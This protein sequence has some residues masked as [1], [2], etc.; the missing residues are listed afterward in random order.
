MTPAPASTAVP[1]Y[2]PP[3][4]PEGAAISPGKLVFPPSPVAVALGEEIAAHYGYGSTFLVD[5]CS[6]ALALVPLV[7][8]WGPGDEILVPA[9]AFPT[10]VSG[11]VWAGMRVRFVDVEPTTPTVSLARLQAARSPATRAVLVLQ[12]AG[13]H[14]ELPAIAAWCESEGL[15]L[16]EDAAQAIAAQQAGRYMGSFGRFAAISFGKTKNLSCGKGG[17]LVVNDPADLDRARA[18]LDHGTNRA[19][20][21]AGTVSEYVWTHLGTNAHLPDLQARVLAAFWPGLAAATRT[22]RRLWQ[23]YATQLGESLQLAGVGFAAPTVQ[24]VHNGHLFWLK[25]A[26]REQRDSL[27]SYLRAENIEAAF[28]YQNLAQAPFWGHDNSQTACP[29]AQAWADGLVRLPLYERLS[30][31]AQDR[32]IEAVRRWAH[33]QTGA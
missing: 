4:L 3:A 1:F 14:P 28:H 31:T 12:Y 29:N 18:V 6:L 24:E 7:A 26:T 10:T 2:Q 13:L 16:V 25:C 9:F 17:A 32:V 27:I 30:E 11:F 22:R 21:L 33:Q 15:S 5:S 20:F 19:A 8:G 23:R